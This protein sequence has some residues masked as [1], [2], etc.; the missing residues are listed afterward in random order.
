MVTDLDIVEWQI[1]IAA[2]EPLTLT[3]KKVHSNG[4]AIEAR[5]YPEDPATSLP[6]TGTIG[7]IKQPKGDHVRI[8]G[9]IF[10]GY[11]VL[12]HYDSLMAKVITWG[13][14]REEAVSTMYKALEQYRIPGLT[15]NIPLVQQALSHPDFT[16]GTYSTRLLTRLDS[17]DGAESPDEA[18]RAVVAAVATALGSLFGAPPQR[19]AS[20]WKAHGRAQ[21]MSSPGRGGRW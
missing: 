10:R 1:R 9:S 17:Q 18:E 6:T 4:H 2:G 3:Q 16:N 12:P 8:D 7:K 5:I 20:S 14:T 19:R 11:E 13:E 21:Q 15:T